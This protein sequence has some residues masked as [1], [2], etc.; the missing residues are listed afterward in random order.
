MPYSLEPASAEH[1]PAL[2]EY[3]PRYGRGPARAGEP[4]SRRAARDIRES[5]FSRR[6]GAEP[7]LEMREFSES[8]LKAALAAAGFSEIRIHSDPHPP[9]GIVYSESWSLPISA[10]KGAFAFSQEAT[11]DV[12]KG[13]ARPESEISRRDETFGSRALVSDRPE[14]AIAPISCGRATCAAGPCAAPAVPGRRCR[15]RPRA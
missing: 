14:V 2:H 13:V 10:R 15:C 1:F 5:G 6:L 12:L 11:R 7:S 4:H 8:Q 9:F 3:R